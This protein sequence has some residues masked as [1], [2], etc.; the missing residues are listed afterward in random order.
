MTLT[1][2]DFVQ[3]APWDF[4]GDAAPEPRETS[5]A[6]VMVTPLENH[7][8]KRGYLTEL[9]TERS[10]PL[11]EPVVH[12]YQVHCAPGSIRGW[13]Y[14]ERQKDRLAYT[15]GHFTLVLYDLRPDSPTHGTLLRLELGEA[16]PA[17]V[18]IPE[19]VA[20]LLRNSGDRMASFVNMPTRV[21]D[22]ADPDKARLPYPDPR[23]PFTF[24]D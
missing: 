8:D 10:S 19:R 5:I 22:L 3:D 21:Y 14:H 18:V 16:N 2:Q 4:A 6:G 9:I 24:D 1:L 13:V 23:I 12:V 17:R 15:E 11:P 7:A 20:H